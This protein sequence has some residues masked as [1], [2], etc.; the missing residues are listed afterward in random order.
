VT[1]LLERDTEQVQVCLSAKGV[2][3]SDPRRTALDLLSL[4][5][6]DGFSSRLFREVRDRRG[7]AYSIYSSPSGYLDCG[8]FNIYFGVAPERVAE[9]LEVVGDVLARVR[10]GDLHDD[11]LEAAKL[12]LRGS[13]LLAHESSGARMGF[14]AEQ[15]L[16]GSDELDYHRDL[17][18]ASATTLGDLRELAAEL[19][20]EPLATAVVGPAPAGSIPEGGFEIRS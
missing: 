10:E 6:G 14:L 7:L 16:L 5:V 1:R 13:T 18:I 2:S 19:L 3:R 9:S 4:A 11:E 12:H 15:A 8:S 17:E 20:A